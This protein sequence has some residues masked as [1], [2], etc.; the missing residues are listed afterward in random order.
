MNRLIIEQ[1]KI[2]HNL[3]VVQSRVGD[4]RI[5]CVLTGNEGWPIL[6]IAQSLSENG[7]SHFA[8]RR[9]ADALILRDAGF[10]TQ[11]ILML[12]PVTEREEIE[13]L[14]A[15]NVVFTV[16]SVDSGFALNQCAKQQGVTAKAHLQ[17][18]TGMG[19]SGFLASESDKILMCYRSLAAVTM[20]GMYTR[21][22]NSATSHMVERQIS[23][24]L[25]VADLITSHGF[26]VGVRHAAGSNCLV[27][28]AYTYLDAVRVNSVLFGRCAK[29]RGDDLKIVGYGKTTITECRWLP[30]GHVVGV[31]AE[32]VIL[33][34]PTRVGVL[35]VGYLH[36]ISFLAPKHLTFFGASIHMPQY[37]EFRVRVGDRTSKIVGHMGKEEMAIDIT[38]LNCSAGDSVAFDLDPQFARAFRIIYSN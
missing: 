29:R 2:I 23:A 14:L 16:S 27:N 4:T 13:T 7:V 15:L 8:V 32:A 26:E 22:H 21:I 34:R 1:S 3:E 25:S 10:V 20:C 5:Y 18:D 37:Q 19:F 38:H 30:K 17:I 36:G 12:R 33:S 11:E 6:P 31:G 9:I 24:F 35:P 28:Q